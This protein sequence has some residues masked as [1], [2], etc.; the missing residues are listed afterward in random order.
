[1][2]KTFHGVMTALATPFTKDGAVDEQAFADHIERQIGQGVHGL[3][4]LGTTGE[5]ATQTA[6]EKKNLVKL[7]VTQTNG[8]VPVIAGAGSSDTAA[9]IATCKAYQELGV[10]G[11]L[12]V[13]PMYNKPSQEGLFRHFQAVHEATELPL[14]AYNVPGRTGINLEPK[15]TGRL[16]DLERVVAI[17]EACGDL[18]QVMEVINAIE[19]KMDL[20][21][22]DDFFFFP[23]LMMGG[24]G[25]ICVTS[26]LVP[27]RVVAIYDAY[28]RE[29]YDQAR[30][31]QLDLL[32]LSQTLFI[33]SNPA[34]VKTALSL[35]GYM[36]P[37]VRLPLAPMRP[38]SMETLKRVLADYHI[39]KR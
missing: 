32:K 23:Y 18:M 27:D 25:I 24:K 2:S 22:G 37:T 3:V 19:G 15:T 11:L 26:N 29:D 28:R 9:T 16:A 39:I 4:V 10:D 34:P 14:I 5:A 38:E 7:C 1:M 36:E 17:K 6:Q 12:I 20:F 33:E 31:I 30:R 13:T 8:R 35:L 21:S